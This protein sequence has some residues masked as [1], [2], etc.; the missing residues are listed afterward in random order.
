VSLLKSIENDVN[1]L[2]SND[3]L[4]KAVFNIA[5]IGIVVVDEAGMLVEANDRVCSMFG[6]DRSE[7]LGKRHTVLHVEEEIDAAVK[8]HVDFFN[9]VHGVEEKEWK[10]LTKNKQ[11]IIVSYSASLLVQ[12]NG[13]R[14]KV[15]SIRDV[16]KERHTEQLLAASKKKY[17]S[18]FDNSLQGF[19]LTK[20]DGTI[21][22]ANK[23]ACDMFG[24]SEP[25]LRKLGRSGIIV[26]TETRFQEKLKERTENGSATGELTGIRKNGENFPIEFSSFV[27]TDNNG[28]L[29]TSTVLTDISIRR[30]QESKL[31]TSQAEMASILNNTEEIFLI[32]DREYKLVNY[33]KAAEERAAEILAMPLKRGESMLQ[34]AEPGRRELVK[35]IYDRTLKGERIR[36]KHKLSKNGETATMQISYLPVFDDKGFCDR[37]MV[38][39]REITIEENALTDITRKQ[40][41][42]QQA[43]AIA[44][45][46]S[47]EL[48]IATNQLYWSDEVFRICGY[49]PGSFPVT[50][51]RWMEVIHP[52]D[53]TS[54]M[55]A[56][57]KAIDEKQDCS[58]HTRFVRPDGSIRQIVA[59]AKPVFN[60]KG[61]VVRMVGVFHDVT[62]VKEVERALAISQ[63]KYKT[64]FDQHPDAVVS[65]D[66]TGKFT[67]VNDAALLLAE[68]SREQL[69]KSDFVQYIDIAEVGEIIRYLLNAANGKS[70]RFETVIVTST[71]RRKSVNVILMPIYIDQEITG[72]YGVLKDITMENLHAEELKFQSHLLN[73]IQ[74]SVIVTKLDG[75]I[76]FWNNFAEK[77]YGWKKEDVV[78]V[79][80]LEVA[81]TE[82]SIEKGK[83]IMSRL[84]QGESWSGE[85]LVKHKTKGPFT[86][87]IH[88]SPLID[89]Q[90]TLIGII[91]VSWDITKEVEAR[92]FIKFQADLLDNVE[93]AV[94][95]CN[96]DGTVFYWNHFAEK[97]YQFSKAEAMGM[98]IEAIASVD[99]Q[100]Q[101]K[102]K[103]LK[104][105]L[106]EG[107]SWTGESY[108]RNKLGNEFPV[109]SMN[110]P[111]F[112][113]EGSVNGMIG[114]SYDITER[115]L[116][117]QQK[118]FDR[119]DKEAL[120][121]STTDLIWS[122]NSEYKLVAANK[123]FLESLKSSS[124]L[125]LQ[126]GDDILAPSV[127]PDDVVA[128]WRAHYSRA[129]GGESFTIELHSAGNALIKEHWDEISFNPI[130]KNK[131]VIAVACRG[132]D[133]SQNKLVQAKLL[134]INNQ[135]ETAQQIAKL[136][137][138]ELDLK[139][140]VLFWSKEVYAIFGIEQA[141][142]AAN[143]QAFF[144]R[145]HPD[146]VASFEEHRIRTLN[147]KG[148]LNIEHRIVLPDQSIKYVVEKG[149]LVYDDAGTAI[150][151][152]GTVQDITERKMAEQELKLSE[153][154]LNLIYNS[155]AGIIFLVG[156]EKEN[157]F[158][159]I[160]MNNAGLAAIGLPTEAVFGKYVNEV[161]PEPSLSL[162][163]EKYR[164]AITTKQSVV[165]H[166]TSNYPTG[167]KVGVVTL[168]PIFDQEG[169]CIRLVGSVNDITELKNIEQSL[170]ISQQEYKSLF[171]Q[172]PDAVYSLDSE[173]NFVSFNPG[174]EKLL[175][176][177][178][179]ELFEA[180]TIDPFCYPDD[181]TKMKHYFEKVL[182]GEP[183]SYHLLVTTL[184][185]N[186]KYLSISNMPIVV[187][188]LITGVYGIAKDSTIQ[189]NAELQLKE[190]FGQLKERAS[191]LEV[192][193]KELERFAYIAS[194][195]LQ[196]PLRM[197]SSFLQLLQKKYNDSIDDK[198]REYIRFAVDGSVRMKRLIN[199]LLD[200]S[201][202]TTRKQELE[203]V[204]VQEVMKE[205]MQ[206]LSL[207]ITEKNAQ[208]SM[209]PL[210]LLE[211]A[212][213]T[214]LTQLLQNL[215]GNALK[216]AGDAAP[217]ISIQCEE[218]SDDWLFSV[219]DNGIGFDQKFAEKIFVIFQRLHNK[220]EYSGTG[221]GLAICKKIVDR[222]AGT[223]SVTSEPGKGSTFYFTISKHLVAD[224]QTISYE[225]S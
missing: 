178:R 166:E 61:E 97:L 64:L 100:Y 218:R 31:R 73:T 83:E 27:F 55:D 18:I 197:V 113:H 7:L 173:G 71:N 171:D 68:T 194:H 93:Q 116:A 21:L 76:I 137:Y 196:E 210:P 190:L 52:G 101:T 224:K 204:D 125:T 147:G 91:G 154:Q 129:L 109:F 80:I 26:E 56:L 70:Q 49:E 5:G 77:L 6:Y 207:Q 189:K 59:K 191:E 136:G 186:S 48:E 45:V 141:E 89:A 157:R 148:L 119:L 104:Q 8:D 211:L 182:Q 50:V 155:T 47:F 198:G 144:E 222:H 111:L 98:N 110:S 122:V 150:L 102:N 63:Q 106:I 167:T 2:H 29:R 127:F 206:N 134:S 112:N 221:I 92:D 123:A 4:L 156:V 58:K 12:E 94:V 66:L 131:Q 175:E 133:I 67:S 117:E 81:P 163:L 164:E 142:F 65:F 99:A 223:I 203:K 195:D 54:S 20:P 132:R 51:E 15:K 199:D 25:E 135:L 169:N 219:K 213:K 57:K 39:V 193:N 60:E 184:K 225:R 62:E 95:A 143:F 85:H 160:S 188:G 172:N 43:E 28:E 14:F 214:Q 13:Q 46:G 220:P 53:R 158:R 37:F 138:W 107:K 78:G 126:S 174:L 202:V 32:I 96:L 185:G 181:R 180:K 34:W 87:Q 79:N 115:K 192:S 200:Y 139:K 151:F 75:T 40:E 176:A 145:I 9:A 3:Q 24:Y 17:K 208:I 82:G 69:L 170:A 88:N 1:G 161:I 201:R 22:E 121:N 120:I 86:A 114:I 177:T 152:E 128:F 205:V 179:E 36:Y 216:Y 140:D 130:V 162:V 215:V 30:E 19:F 23:A 165:W 146:D 108:M 183:Q 118:E 217:E 35:Q 41:L 84:S 42:L 72:V 11:T 90:G 38:S 44:H 153:E 74:Q 159:F 168:T 10:G 16:T 187:N 33:N 103:E 149:S 124:N 105:L 212:D 209:S